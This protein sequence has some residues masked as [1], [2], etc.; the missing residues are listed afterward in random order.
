M[1]WQQESLLELMSPSNFDET[2]VQLLVGAIDF[3]TDNRVPE[4]RKVDANLVGPP[5]AREGAD[6][7]K[8]PLGSS[9]PNES[10]FHP[11]FGHG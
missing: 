4:V 6:N 10:L 1:S 11:K 8:L 2:Q 9:S 5:R 7:G 3:V